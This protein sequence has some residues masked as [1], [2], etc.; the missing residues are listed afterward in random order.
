VSEVISANDGIMHH[1]YLLGDGFM[2]RFAFHLIADSLE[3]DRFRLS[4]PKVAKSI[5]MA[6]LAV[7]GDY[8]L[9]EYI[10]ALKHSLDING[11]QPP[12]EEQIDTSSTRQAFDPAKNLFEGFKDYDLSFLHDSAIIIPQG[13]IKDYDRKRDHVI[14]LL[15][16]FYS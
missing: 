11:I 14:K 4:Y 5:A 2:I 12:Q 16:P 10:S 15:H 6:M 3:G 7:K 13:D 1:K 8:Y 9:S